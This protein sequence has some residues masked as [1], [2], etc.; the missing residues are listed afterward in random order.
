MPLPTATEQPLATPLPTEWPTTTPGATP[1]GG[2]EEILF[3]L[4]KRVDEDYQFVGVYL[5]NLLTRKKTELYGQGYQLQ[6]LSPD[7]RRILVNQ[8]QQLFLSDRYGGNRQLLSDS[9]YNM[10]LPAARW[11]EDNNLVLWIEEDAE[12]TR[13]MTAR[14]N[15]ETIQAAPAVFQDHPVAIFPSIDAENIIWAKGDCSAFSICIQD[16]QVGSIITESNQAWVNVQRP[17]ISKA[18]NWLAFLTQTE[19]GFQLA[20]NQGI[21]NSSPQILDMAGDI[22][23]DYAWSPNEQELLVLGQIRSDYSGKSFGN[24]ILL[25]TQPDWKKQQ[26]TTVDGING[27]I[28]WSPDGQ[29]FVVTTTEIDDSGYWIG[30]RLFNLPGNQLT[31]FDDQLGLVSEDFLFVSGIF[32]VP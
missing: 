1:A 11:S 29:N 23:V 9:F 18:G 7:G 22:A 5:L 8:G 17:H 31:S 28:D 2:S 4:E 12:S 21:D 30:M 25:F 14:A 6:A 16:F 26:V 24:N 3:S 13:L 20:I 32:W 15:G 19:N 27:R 10:G